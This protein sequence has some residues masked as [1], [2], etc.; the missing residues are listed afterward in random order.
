MGKDTPKLILFIGADWWGSDARSLAMAFR[1]RGHVLIEG[2]PEDFKPTAWNSTP[3]KI[4][5]R[6]IL[7]LVQRDYNRHILRLLGNQ[8][9]DFVVVFKG[10][11]LESTTVAQIAKQGLKSYC[12]Y[13][14]VSLR[15][16]G[17]AIWEA[18]PHYDCLFTTKSFHLTDPEIR[19][20][21]KD[22][23][24]VNHGFDPDV[25]RP[26]ADTPK[27]AA[28]YRCDV[29]FVG[30]WSPKKE[31]L[32]KAIIR[33]CPDIRLRIWGVDWS[34]GDE[35]IRRF[36]EGRGAFGDELCAVYRNSRINLGLLSEAG[37]GVKMGDQTTARTW[38]IPACSGFMLHEM[39]EELAQFFNPEEE[40]GTFRYDP[41]K[42]AESE[43]S[44]VEQ[45]RHYLDHDDRRQTVGAA[46]HRRCLD[47]RYTH[48]DTA[49]RI[50]QYHELAIGA[51]I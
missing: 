36:W 46:G 12:F 17:A 4:V 23:Q 15:D 48:D 43:A 30:C 10:P 40:V 49:R 2:L 16:H 29:S 32:L 21:A 51:G 38:Q 14:D 13:P 6:L 20:R 50:V 25:H 19:S 42:P 27:Q 1:H 44:L 18:I 3:L 11:M 37:T 9:I 24:L 35:A 41:A 33:G 31:N 22:I 47:S 39:T 45:V 34:M 5:R 26:V 8:A 7:P 28:R